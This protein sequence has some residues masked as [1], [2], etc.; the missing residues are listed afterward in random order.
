MPDLATQPTA[1]KGAGARC[2]RRD[3][4]ARA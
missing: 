2:G 4:T 3:E 1:A